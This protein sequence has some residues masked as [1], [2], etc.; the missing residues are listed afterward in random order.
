MGLSWKNL[1][2]G[3][4]NDSIKSFQDDPLKA[5]RK[6]TRSYIDPWGFSYAAE[7]ALEGKKIDRGYGKKQRDLV[8]ELLKRADALKTP[9]L[10]DLKFNRYQSAG[11]FVPQLLSGL[12]LT[13]PEMLG[14]SRL[15]GVNYDPRLMGQQEKVL[16]TLM[17]IGEKGGLRPEDLAALDK[18]QDEVAAQDRGRRQAILQNMAARGMSG[19][20]NELLAQLQSNQAATDRANDASLNIAGQASQR[21]LKALMD[22][23][24]LARSLANDKVGLDL[25]KANAADAIA[26]FNINARNTSQAANNRILNEMLRTNNVMQNNAARYNL[27]SNQRVMDRNTDLGNREIDYNQRG[28]LQQD[29][30]NRMNA[31]NVYANAAAAAQGH[32]G[33]ERAA[34]I[35][36]SQSP[37][38]RMFQ[39]AMVG[40]K[41]GGPWGAVIGGAV[42]GYSQMQ[43]NKNAQDRL[44]GRGPYG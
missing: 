5:A 43:D 9:E 25:R 38:G 19:S 32:Y 37:L 2:V 1:S 7:N 41:A 18:I 23:G 15:Q 13:N 39:G 11:E 17:E 35:A 42:G 30:N 29:Y 34:D 22:G 44:I 33:K 16:Q 21:A 10:K 8:E 6:A 14:D 36:A 24:S 26:K 28:K 4:L 27:E 40:G 12:N 31:Y 3:G 20:G